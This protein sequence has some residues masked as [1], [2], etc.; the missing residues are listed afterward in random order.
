MIFRKDLRYLRKI[1][2][3][4]INIRLLIIDRDSELLNN[5]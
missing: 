5:R 4:T 1:G 3:E 2:N